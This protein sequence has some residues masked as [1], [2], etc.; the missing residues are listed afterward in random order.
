LYRVKDNDLVSVFCI[1]MPLLPLTFVE[2]AVFS[3]LYVFGNFVKNQ[4]SI[5]VWIHDWVLSSVP[6]IFI[7]VFVLV[8]CW[9]YCY[10]SVV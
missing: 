5:A 4:M 3:V 6:L 1:E 9:F 2:E 8:P 7:S 10:G